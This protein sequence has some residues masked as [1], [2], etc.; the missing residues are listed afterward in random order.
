MKKLA[1]LLA[2]LLMLTSCAAKPEQASEQPS[3]LPT[4][5]PSLTVTD[6]ESQRSCGSGSYGWTYALE[7]GQSCHTLADGIHP[8]QFDREPHLTTSADTVTLSFSPAPERTPTVRCWSD[9]HLGDT[10]AAAEK[11]TLENSTLT[12]KEGGWIYEVS[13]GWEAD[14]GSYSGSASYILYIVKN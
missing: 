8:L 4:E 14:D 2:L 10:S 9:E 7:N 1:F 11:P 3:D 12:L 6:G 5:P 13:A